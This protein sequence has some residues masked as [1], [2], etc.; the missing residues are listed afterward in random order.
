MGFVI[1]VCL[2]FFKLKINPKLTIWSPSLSL[3]LECGGQ[4]EVVNSNCANRGCFCHFFIHFL[5]NSQKTKIAVCVHKVRYD[6][7]NIEVIH[8]F[9]T[10]CGDKLS[11]APPI[12]GLV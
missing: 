1:L 4:V 8:N 5:C 11:M 6:F 12:Y 3:E 9:H 10:G 7:C 2:L